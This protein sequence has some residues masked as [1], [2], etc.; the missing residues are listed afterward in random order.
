MKTA[1]LIFFSILL[2]IFSIQESKACHAIALVNTSLTVGAGSVTVNASSD[3]P[4]CGCDLYW[5][6]V[7]VRCIGEPFDGAP[8]NPGFWGPLDTYPYFQSIKMEKNDCVVQPYPPVTIPFGNLCPGTQYQVRA[9][10]NHHGQVG[11]WCATMTFTVPGTLP[12][13]ACDATAADPVICEGDCTDLEALIIGGC[14]LAAS[15]DWSNLGAGPPASC[16]FSICLYDTFGDGWN[17]GSVSVVVNGVTVLSNVTLANGSGPACYDFTVSSGQTITVNYTAG[18]WSS[19]NYYIIYDGSG[20][21]GSQVQSTPQG[22]TPP[23]SN[24]INNNCGGTDLGSP[25]QNVCPIVTTTYDVIITELCSNQTV[26][27]AVTVQVLP[28]PVAGTAAISAPS[29]CANQTVDLSLA[30]SA[31]VIQWQSAPNAGGPWTNIP[32]GTDPNFTTDPLTADLCFRAEVTGCGP[33]VYSNIVCVTI[34]PAPTVAVQDE[35]ICAGQSVTL[36]AVPSAGGGTYTWTPGGQT[37]NSITVSPAVTTTYDVEYILNNCPGNASATVT[38]APQPVADFT[39]VSACPGDAVTFT[40]TSTGVIDNYEWDIDNDGTIDYTTAD[41]NHVFGATGSYDVTLIVSS[42]GGCTNQITQTIDVYS[43][44]DPNFEV[45][46]VCITN[47]S[48]FLD[49]STDATGNINSWTWDFGGGNTSTDQHPSHTF[50]NTGSHPVTLTVTSDN[51][52]SSNI[53]LNA[54][55]INTPVASFNFTNDCFYNGMSFQNTSTAGIPNHSWNFG[56]GNTSNAVNPNHTYNAPG[57]YTVTLEISTNDGCGDQITQTVTAYH[58]PTAGFTGTSVC[59]GD[60]NIFTDNSVVNGALGDNITNWSW[61]FGDGNTSAVQNPSHSYLN[62]NTYNATLTVTTNNGCTD[63]I[64]VPVTVYP[65]PVAAFTSSVVCFGNG[66]QFTN[67]STVSSVNSPNNI[68]SWDW[69]FGDGGTSNA[70][71]PTYVYT[72]AGS[73]NATLTVTSNNGCTHQVTLPVFVSEGPN[74]SFTGV[75]LDGCS[76]V[77]FE[78]TSTSTSTSGIADLTWN[79]SNGATYNGNVVGDCFENNTGSTVSLGVELI[80]TNTEG[81]SNSHYE[82]DFI[83]IYHNPVAYFTYT[84][85]DPDI[86][87]SEVDFINSSLN[88]TNFIWNIEGHGTSNDHSP[89]VDFG[90][91]ADQYNVELIAITENGCTDTVTSIVNVLDR[92]IF[93]V[94]NTFTPDFDDYNQFF[95]PIFTSGFDPLD[96]NL[97]IYNRWGEVIFESNDASIGWDGTYGASSDKIVRDGTYIWKIEFKETM[98]DKRHVHTGHVN[99][100]R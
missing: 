52:C 55:V 64:T 21:S 88:A 10:E 70:Q 69:D 42:N 65:T 96:Y 82:P 26:A 7:E 22:Q 91:I 36:T 4:T 35:T 31:G 81:C 58:Q 3:S 93:Y 2:S 77:C 61:E 48:L 25:T 12:T 54:E 78:L 33:L 14:G 27:C 94:P 80:V 23:G 92:I 38:I 87:F 66:T 30:G 59:E 9:R 83:N 50:L 37:T 72:A 29:V 60:A 19:E 68:A 86:M 13:L 49:L 73:F 5:L 6:D 16:T 32:G 45:S 11:P 76:P 47:P 17:G 79:I 84:P 57:E 8:F 40:N 63:D 34:N 20:G 41:I 74:V 75:N 85:T 95:T 24:S 1:A 28:P 100:L 46:T 67:S 97:L 53:T 15:Y 51:G 39:F 98:T 56:D 99:L 89:S 71:N 62:E 43:I 90:E 44:P 18:S